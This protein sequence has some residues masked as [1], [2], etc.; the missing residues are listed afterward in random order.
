MLLALLLVGCP[1]PT[2]K[3]DDPDTAET[4]DPGTLAGPNGPSR[5]EPDCAPD[6]GAAVRLIVGLEEA[7]CDSAFAGVPHLRLSLWVGAEFPLAP[8]TYPF[9]EGSGSAWYAQA[10]GGVEQHARSGEVTVTGSAGGVVTGSYTLQLDGGEV[11]AGEFEAAE[12]E[13][14]VMCG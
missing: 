7:T 2:D 4:A 13:V 14:A 10:G 3:S 1:A 12:C 5:I 9:D 11:V 6:D 8:G